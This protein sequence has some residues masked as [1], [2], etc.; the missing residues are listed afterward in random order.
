MPENVISSLFKRFFQADASI[1]RKYGG[2]GLGLYICKN[3]IDAHKG[4]IWVESKV[5]VG[6]TIHV[7]LPKKN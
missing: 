3:I 7:R 2:T 4:E 1:T 6:T 5:G